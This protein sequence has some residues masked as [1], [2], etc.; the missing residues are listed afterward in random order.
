MTASVGPPIAGMPGQAGEILR[1]ADHDRIAVGGGA[2]GTGKRA[3]R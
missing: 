3:P 1:R 2:L